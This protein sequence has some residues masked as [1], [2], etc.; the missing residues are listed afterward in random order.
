MVTLIIHFKG[1]NLSHTAKLLLSKSGHLYRLQGLD[2]D[3]P[4]GHYSVGPV[5]LLCVPL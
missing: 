1:L 5:K 4:A 3:V 2:P